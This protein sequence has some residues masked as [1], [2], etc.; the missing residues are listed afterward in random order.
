LSSSFATSQDLDVAVERFDLGQLRETYLEQGRFLC[1][2][3]FLPESVVSAWRR[4]VES[5][6]A[7]AHRSHIPGH[8]R[9]GSI[10][11]STI[12][13]E[14]PSVARVY[15]SA[16]FR[17]FLEAVVGEKILLCPNHDLHGCAVYL[18]SRAGDHIGFHYDTSYYRGRRYTVLLGIRNDSQAKLVYRL[19]TKDR[20]RTPVDGEVAV[21]PGTL[22]VFDG[23]TVL[24]KVT[25]LGE[26]EVRWVA[27]MQYVTDVRMRRTLRFV[28][29][30]KDAIA[31]FGFRRIFGPRRAARASIEAQSET[32]GT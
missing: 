3:Q 1:I 25:P 28:S 31:Y 19:H 9:G 22:V 6:A 29:D 24:H 20:R 30:M 15:G 5:I 7:G 8:K 13:S 11:R 14:A 23:D 18:Y 10:D 26:G 12:E 32:V 21:E 4:E 16:L 2:P 17:E 27:S